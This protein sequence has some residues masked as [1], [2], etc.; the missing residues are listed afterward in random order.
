MLEVEAAEDPILVVVTTLLGLSVYWGRRWNWPVWWRCAVIFYVVWVLLYSTFFTNITG[1]GSGMWQSLGY[2]IVQQGEARGGQPWYY[3]FVLTSIY[4]FLPLFFS[5]LAA[6]Y[7]WRRGDEFGRFLVYWS[8][9][10]FTLY[11]VASEKM[12]WLLVNLALPLIVLSGKLLNDL[13]REIDWRRLVRRGGLL[14]LPGVPLFV[15]VAWWLAFY[16]GEGGTAE[17]LVSVATAVVLAGLAAA[18]GYMTRRLGTANLLAFSALPLAALLMVLTVRAGAMATYQHGADPVEMIVYTQSSP[19][20]I[21]VRD[22][23]ERARDLDAD[24]G[25]AP[26]SIDP[27]SGFSWPWAWYLRDYDDVSYEKY[28]DGQGDAP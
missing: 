13:V 19:D 18:G 4:E 7:Y 5:V 23:I 3:Y 28:V 26:I 2:W 27:T 10:N 9:A 6:I 12:P 11:A 22:R 20:I 14:L 1:I 8:V 21:S 16:E 24:A 15:V 17:L 25:A